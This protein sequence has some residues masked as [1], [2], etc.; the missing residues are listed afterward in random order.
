MRARRSFESVLA[1]AWCA[2]AA[3]LAAQ[4]AGSPLARECAYQQLLQP[5]DSTIP[6]EWLGFYPTAQ[7]AALQPQATAG[8]WIAALDAV[9]RALNGAAAQGGAATRPEVTRLRERIE[10]T[11]RR[12]QVLLA[13]GDSA[14]YQARL[15]EVVRFVGP[16]VFATELRTNPATGERTVTLFRGD[17]D[18]ISI[19][20]STPDA[21]R[22][23][24]CWSA[25]ATRWLMDRYTGPMREHAVAFIA[26]KRDLWT[27]YYE[28]GYS[29]LPW[30]LLLN[31]RLL[32]DD[33]RLDP[34]TVQWVLLHPSVG[35]EVAVGKWRDLRRQE[36]ITLELLGWLKYR[37]GYRRYRGISGVVTFTEGQGLGV[38]PFVHFSRAA[39]AGY[40][41]R[42]RRP[43][44]GTRREHGVLLSVD[45]YRYL[46]DNRTQV[47]QALKLVRRK[48]GA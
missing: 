39:K 23:T 14:A 15:V 18:A 21:V 9:E 30:E 46:D 31:S 47:E 28:R 29:Q 37:D 42:T 19:A 36:T 6:A 34:P 35:A 45:L 41:F 1:I 22:R 4:R 38:G 3:P 5:A 10:Q 24:V 12:V 17:P 48:V 11:R 7:F 20:D 27:R 44:D 40:V 32:A 25:A 43:A 13:A 33:Q 26:A 16:G 2:L 8:E